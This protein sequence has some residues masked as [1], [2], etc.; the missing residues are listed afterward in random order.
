MEESRLPC[1]HCSYPNLATDEVCSLCGA[2]RRADA[3]KVRISAGGPEIQEGAPLPARAEE[4][5]PS[6]GAARMSSLLDSEDGALPPPPPPRA[7]RDRDERDFHPFEA[8]HVQSAARS[9]DDLSPPGNY[10]AEVRRMRDAG[11]FGLPPLLFAFLA[12]GAAAALWSLVPGL[13]HTAWILRSF[14]HEI[15]HALAGWAMGIPSIPALNPGGHAATMH[16]EPRTW[17]AALMLLVP[18]G[19]AWRWR[20]NLALAIP[21]AVAVPLLGLLAFTPMRDLFV[22]YGGHL[23]EILFGTIFFWR[24]FQGGFSRFAEE[25]ALYAAVGFMLLGANLWLSFGLLLFPSVQAWYAG[26][27]SFGGENDYLRIASRLGVTAGSAAALMLVP[28]FLSLPFGW[29]L[30]LWKE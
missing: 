1:P 12:G 27:G 20:E 6:R 22:L 13:A 25:R 28:A 23:G 14:F 8:M 16:L 26:S 30:S 11:P 21:A 15:G 10:A 7:G 2:V 5:G 9:T 29:I 24:M 3:S 18:C 17:L 19:L 4:G